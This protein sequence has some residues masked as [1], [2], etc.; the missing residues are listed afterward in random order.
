MNTRKIKPIFVRSFYILFILG[1]TFA[2]TGVSYA[3]ARVPFLGHWYAVDSDGSNMRLNI[4]GP[5]DGPFNITWV[6]DYMSYCDGEAGIIRG[7]G[8]INEL[9]VN[10]LE[11][12]LIAECFTTGDSLPFHMTFR[13][14]PITLTLS[15]QYEN[16]RMI[17]WRRAGV[18]PEVPSLGLRVNY[19]D[20]WVEGFY[21]AGHTAWVT[22][23]EGDG[24]TV[25]ATAE[26]FTAPRDEWSGQSGFQTTPENWLPGQPDIQPGDWVYGW[27]D[28][29]ASAQVQIG[30]I[31][32][33]VST[34]G[35]LITGTV[36]A[37]FLSDLEVECFPWGSPDPV[38]M[39]YDQVYPDDVDTYTC[40]WASEWDIQP[41][42]SVGVG[43]I[44]LDDQWVATT[45][46][47]PEPR[48]V[49][50]ESG[51][52]FWTSG[53]YPGMLDI[54]IYASDAE[55][56]DLL[57]SGQA[58]ADEGGFAFVGRETH[59]QDL[60]EG[61]YLVISDGVNT[62]GIVLLPISVTVF[63]TE[64]EIMAGYAPA[65][66]EVWA[67][68]GPAEWQER[69][70]VMAD[71]E[72]G[73]WEAD[74]TSIPFDIL[75]EYRPWSYAHIYDEDG[76]A[77]EG[78]TPPPPLNPHFTIFPEWDWYDGMDWPDGAL[79][80]I[81]VDGKEDPCTAQVESWGY[82]F[83]GGFPEGCDV[84]IGD[85]VR[86]DDGSTT[87]THVVQNLSVTGWDVDLDTLT[88]TAGE[89]TP[90][91][92]WP[93][94]HDYAMQTPVAEP[95]DT[96]TADFSGVPFDL[97][98]YQGGRAIIYGDFGNATAVDWY[99][100]NPH[101]IIFP[102]WDWYDAMDWPDGA[103]VTITVDGK[104][105]PCT[106][107][108]VSYGHFFNGGFP[109]GCD[110]V[111][112]D[113]VRMTDGTTTRFHTVQNLAI[114]GWDVFA[115]MVSGTADEGAQLVV[116]VHEHDESLVYPVAGPGGTW[117]ADFA[118]VGFDLDY[119]MG[120]RAII[121]GD[122]NNATAVDWGIPE[123]P[124]M[125]I[126]I[127]WNSVDG[128][129]WGLYE[130]VTL[131]IGGV[132]LTENTGYGTYVHFEV[133]NVHDIVPGDLV[134]MSNGVVTK[135]MVVPPLVITGY[136][137]DADTVSGTGDPGLFIFTYVDGQLAEEVTWIDDTWTAFF[138]EL[139]EEQWGDAVQV[140]G[141]NDA[142]AATIHTVAP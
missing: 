96:W 30:E 31:T 81:T 95:G 3:Y 94:E 88:G 19:G 89:G 44:G 35:D 12:D 114:T 139:L 104:E 38:D 9:N 74:F 109:E 22:V 119:E 134:V 78:G 57:W 110:V 13:Y 62:K 46:Y 40:S 102:E 55:G 28:N 68:A 117:M 6:D 41:W 73:W 77:N 108:H 76:D 61:N 93:H 51:D 11:A 127:E 10:L 66:S 83:N 56:A 115:D 59:G 116:W 34:T 121:Y 20:E 70:P 86:M 67:A 90:V 128:H 16:G 43:Y 45:F 111:V 5:P 18:V 129:G 97:D 75:E 140:D 84:V 27:V 132:V 69:I 25:K 37:P 32:G 107:T 125:W 138:E 17:I 14:H 135:E 15:S 21:E 42:Q 52:W 141:D 64:N 136:D 58:E 105:D 4:G 133:G 112:G 39:E 91:V 120:G 113:T 65:G 82:F 79:V 7:T 87:R 92:V 118:S 54:S 1:V 71:S 126:W 142:A 29:G 33:R 137:L 106:A 124:H 85:T 103:T 47:A 80:T 8:Y 23:T 131:T 101:F 50:S 24:W 98:Y 36:S 60:V 48:I 122:Y 123:A 99:I 72:T 100:Y 53:F 26:V 63:D 2:F 130:D 49:A